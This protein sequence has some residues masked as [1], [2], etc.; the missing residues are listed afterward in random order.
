MKRF[1]K[2]KKNRC[3]GFTLMETLLAITLFVIVISSSCGV[4]LMG[5]QIWKRTTGHSRNEQRVYLVLEK[6]MTEIQAVLPVPHEETL[7][8][9]ESTAMKFQGD[10]KSFLFPA[11]IPVENDKGA[12]TY[13]SGGL[14]YAWNSSKQVLCR[15]TLT[16]EDFFLRKEAACKN[17]LT[18]IKRADFEYLVSNPGNKSYSWYKSWDSKDGIPR[19]VRISF[20]VSPLDKKKEQPK[21]FLKTFWIPVSDNLSTE[22]RSGAPA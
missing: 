1:H 9:K 3:L 18:D 15:Q 4:F 6:M 2:S 13:Q 16:A 14:G 11:V 21:I 10:E 17:L 5:V 22:L 8:L 7:I 20:E 12:M 19:A